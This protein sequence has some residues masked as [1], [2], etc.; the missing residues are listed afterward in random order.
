VGNKIY[1]FSRADAGPY[2]MRATGVAFMGLDEV[3]CYV[4]PTLTGEE[5]FWS[6]AIDHEGECDPLQ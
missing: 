2:G 4:M 6:G 3:R 5:E 1:D